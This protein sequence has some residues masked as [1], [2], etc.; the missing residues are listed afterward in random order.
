MNLIKKITFFFLLSMGLIIFF[1]FFLILFADSYRFFFS[2]KKINTNILEVSNLSLYDEIEWSKNFF[3]EYSSLEQEYK[4]YLGWRTKEF[5]GSHINIDKEGNRLT[6]YKGDPRDEVKNLFF[7]GSVTWGYGNN[8]A[9]TISSHY[10]QISKEKSKNLG[11]R[12]WVLDQ[13]LIY[14]IQQYNKSQSFTN[15]FF[16]YGLNDIYIKCLSNNL[17]AHGQD[18]I[19]R[20]K[21]DKKIID[22]ASFE[23][24]FSVYK[25]YFIILKNRLG[26]I[27]NSN[28]ENISNGNFCKDKN[29]AKLVAKNIISNL[30]NAK[31]IVEANNDNF[32]AIL[33]P[34][35]L[36]SEKQN[37][38]D[39]AHQWID[40]ESFLYIYDLIIKSEK[41]FDYFINLSDIFKENTEII[42]I[43][44]GGHLSPKGNQLFAESLYLNINKK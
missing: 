7:G 17:Y 13:D 37:H 35:H 18:K 43:D 11:E 36:F 5:K 23:N 8:D 6:F 2:K 25:K 26:F 30:H 39:T 28:K 22:P 12:S 10:S 40:A 16:I 29:Y 27:F 33:Q 20:N 31:K 4:S 3:L 38:L 1:H 44:T 34:V 41:D 21:L 15:I 19:I 14:L 9:N 24:F 32:Y 42:F